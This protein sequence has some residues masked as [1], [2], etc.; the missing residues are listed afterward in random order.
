MNLSRK[1]DQKPTNHSP[2]HFMILPYSRRTSWTQ[3]PYIKAIGWLCHLL[4]LVLVLYLCS[5]NSIHSFR[6]EQ[7]FCGKKCYRN[8]ITTPIVKEMFVLVWQIIVI[9]IIIIIFISW[10]VHSQIQDLIFAVALR[11]NGPTLTSFSNT[12]TYLKRWHTVN[13]FKH[14]VLARI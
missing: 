8:T 3:K 9:I 1:A 14:N 11:K 2:L 5:H 12:D 10:G 6:S 7:L 13:N 4:R